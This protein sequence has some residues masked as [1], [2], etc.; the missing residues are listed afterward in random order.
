MRLTENTLEKLIKGAILTTVVD[1]YANHLSNRSYGE[2]RAYIHS[3]WV[4][5][6]KIRRARSR[7]PTV[8]IL[9]RRVEH[10]RRAPFIYAILAAS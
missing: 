10:Q 8:V 6:A 7:L 2:L 9:V 3:L 5:L 1:A 4:G